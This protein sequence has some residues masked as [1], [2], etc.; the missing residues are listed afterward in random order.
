M[1]KILKGQNYQPR[2][3]SQTEKKK[4]WILIIFLGAMIIQLSIFLEREL[5]GE[6]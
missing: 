6:V 5:I 3:S 2:L 1:H 4:S